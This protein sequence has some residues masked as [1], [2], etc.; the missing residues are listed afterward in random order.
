MLE[1]PRYLVD[2]DLNPVKVKTRKEAE[3]YPKELRAT[4][5][6]WKKDFPG[7]VISFGTIEKPKRGRRK[8]VE[9]GNGQSDHN[10]STEEG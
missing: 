4:N 2:S 1:F 7:D 3:E 9:D 6:M 10:G 5:G 8:K